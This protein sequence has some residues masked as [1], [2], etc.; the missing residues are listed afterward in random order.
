[1]CKLLEREEIT[2][3][4]Y[5]LRSYSTNYPS[6]LFNRSKYQNASSFRIYFKFN[7]QM[8]PRIRSLPCYIIGKLMNPDFMLTRKMQSNLYSREF[9]CFSLHIP[10][11]KCSVAQLLEF[12]MFDVTPS[13]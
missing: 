6:F 7:L 1:M 12:I 4:F 8:P 5:S 10:L 9:S 3:K 11:Q 2:V 13:K